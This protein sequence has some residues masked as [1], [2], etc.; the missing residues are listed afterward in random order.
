MKP[1]FIILAIVGI[2][3]TVLWYY[4]GYA[5]GSKSN[6][7]HDIGLAFLCAVLLFFSGMFVYSMYMR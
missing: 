4:A 3:W 2:A 5:D 6:K 1:V 7:D